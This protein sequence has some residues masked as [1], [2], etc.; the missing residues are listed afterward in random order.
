MAAEA[1]WGSS[2]LA[3]QRLSERPTREETPAVV[4]AGLVDDQ[5]SEGSHYDRGG[6]AMVDREHADWLSPA[7]KFLGCKSKPDRWQRT[8]RSSRSP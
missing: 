6:D 8:H 1:R 7:E 5:L 4:G 2:R 3:V